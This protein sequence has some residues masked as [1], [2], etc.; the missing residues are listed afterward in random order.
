LYSP[1]SFQCLRNWTIRPL[2]PWATLRR[3]KPID[4]AVLP[5]PVRSKGYVFPWLSPADLA[6][7][8]GASTGILRLGSSD[9]GLA[10]GLDTQVEHLCT[11]AP[12]AVDGDAFALELVGRR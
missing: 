6:A 7:L 1:V 8:Y 12:V 9:L 4:A 10:A 3:A 5:P 2:C 11:L